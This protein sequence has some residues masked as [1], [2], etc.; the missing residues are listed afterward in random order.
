MLKHLE[1]GRTLVI[2]ETK[3]GDIQALDVARGGA[4][5]WQVARQVAGPAGSTN[6]GALWGGALDDRN[7]YLPGGPTGITAFGISDGQR[8]WSVRPGVTENPKVQ[9]SAAVTAIPGVLFACAS[10]G[11]LWALSSDDGHALWSYQTA[12]PFT[13]VNA[14]A[15]HG[16]SISSAGATVAGS[17]LFVG[18]GYGVVMDTPGNVLLAFGVQ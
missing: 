4:I 13:T 7:V 10:D 17:M 3:P 14:V 12:H 5:V 11:G 2:F 1:D 9:Y 8:R 15:A 6:R 18:S 16:G